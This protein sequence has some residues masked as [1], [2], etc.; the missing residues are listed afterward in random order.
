MDVVRLLV[1]RS[2]NVNQ[3]TLEGATPLHFACKNKNLLIVKHLIENGAKVNDVDNAGDT[4][5]HYLM[6]A[7][8]NHNESDK[9]CLEQLLKTT[10]VN[11][12]LCNAVIA[13]P[14]HL[15]IV[16]NKVT[17]AEMLIDFLTNAEERKRYINKPDIGKMTPLMLAIYGKH[18]ALCEKL[19]SS[20]ADPNAIINSE[21]HI[22][23]NL[24]PLHIACLSNVPRLVKLLIPI[25]NTSL[26]KSLLK[27]S[28]DKACMFRICHENLPESFATLELL[29]KELNAD[30]YVTN[31]GDQM[32]ISYPA[33]EE[34]E[35]EIEI[36]SSLRV[37]MAP[38]IA[39]TPLTHFLRN[40]WQWA[41]TDDCS[42][43]ITINIIRKY[44]ENG[45]SVNSLK[46]PS[47]RDFFDYT[48]PPILGLCLIRKKFSIDSKIA[49]V[50]RKV[51]DYML[52]QGAKVPLHSR[53]FVCLSAHPI[54]F[55]AFCE[56]G[57]IMVEDI[58]V[59]RVITY[60][61][62]YARM[63]PNNVNGN[64]YY[65]ISIF[66]YFY[67]YG[68]KN[69]WK[70]GL[71]FGDLET[72]ML[73]L[74][75]LFKGYTMYDRKLDQSN[76]ALVKEIS[77]LKLCRVVIRNQVRSCNLDLYAS[78][79]SL[80]VGNINKLIMKLPTLPYDLYDFLCLKTLRIN[81]R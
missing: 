58:N 77:L 80:E 76:T 29:L 46:I 16:R 17:L 7:K 10:N 39:E 35:N 36:P 49:N 14:L 20:G 8:N 64:E 63:D 42:N 1:G 37:Y 55:K 38:Y 81:S 69:N 57:T 68:V 67:L 56:S 19:L 15:A 54:I 25:T 26:I 51:V 73:H 12:D 3:R 18:L 65:S 23:N 47:S 4:A 2:A 74:E 34:N 71:Q 62:S 78:C 27:T 31:F 9:E 52:E 45:S 33:D 75:K 61:E 70:D 44:V 72:C 13:S 30:D 66:Y 28:P 40:N 48:L 53:L 6:E 24:M 41:V 22:D 32:P 60:V 79:N 50:I 5:L 43:D 59:K 21:S 11:I